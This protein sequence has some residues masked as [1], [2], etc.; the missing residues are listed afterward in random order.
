[1]HEPSNRYN[2][3]KI[4]L[5]IIGLC[6]NLA[7]L[8]WFLFSGVSHKLRDIAFSLHNNYWV[9]LVI[10]LALFGFILEALNLPLDFYNGFTIEHRYNLSMQTVIDWINDHIK[11]FSLSAIIGMPACALI[12]YLLRIAPDIWWILFAAAFILFTV[13]LTNL[14]PIVILP[15][16]FKFKPLSD[17]GLA[18]RLKMLSNRTGIMV[19]GVFEWGLGK[20]T[21]KANAGL[22]GLGNTKRIIIADTLLNNFSNEEIEAVFAHELGHYIKGHILRLVALQS[23]IIFFSF[24][25]IDIIIKKTLVYFGYSNIS[26]FANLP[27]LVLVLTLVGL[28]TLPLIN[29]YSRILETEADR[30][31]LR[32]VNNASSFISSMEKLA[33][34]NLADVAP[35]PL[36]EF[37]FY[38][39]PSIKKRL[40]MA[41]RFRNGEGDI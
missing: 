10:Y 16:F 29:G 28:L 9:S 18:E 19:K 26:D 8:L 41:E 21:K 11:E 4:T 35:N 15:L 3:T 39:H 23:I 31:S 22:V 6:L 14:A 20:K 37:I 40:R 5:K 33:A 32:L 38:S 27:L 36:V 12:Y 24:F 1:M 2:K 17:E 30:F 7:V 25:L 13:I 34:L